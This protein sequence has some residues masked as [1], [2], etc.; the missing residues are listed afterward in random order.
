MNSVSHIIFRCEDVEPRVLL[1]GFTGAGSLQTSFGHDGFLIPD[2]GG[3][4]A[5]AV[6]SDGKIVVAGAVASRDSLDFLTARLNS[7]GSLD[8][9]FGVGGKVVTDFGNQDVALAIAIQ[10]DGKIVVAGA[11]GQNS[12]VARYT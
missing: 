7:N 4:S 2:F 10:A 3:V 6:Q 5:V 12:A 8:R 1:S 11:S 9:T